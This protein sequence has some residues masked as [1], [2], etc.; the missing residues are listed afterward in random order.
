MASMRIYRPIHSRA[1]SANS[2]EPAI[3]ARATAD[4]TS[5]A[6]HS[7]QGS[8][9]DSQSLDMLCAGA[10]AVLEDFEVQGEVLG[11][12][13]GAALSRDAQR[14]PVFGKPLL[15][16]GEVS[17]GADEPLRRR[18]LPRAVGQQRGGEQRKVERERFTGH[19]P[20]SQGAA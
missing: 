5:T 15:G 17:L 12:A 20:F 14:G 4:R 2:A 8:R 11:A 7:A 6:A 3:A 19:V 18:A 16:L 1:N 9:C 10:F 13:A